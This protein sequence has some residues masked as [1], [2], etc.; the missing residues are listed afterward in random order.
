MSTVPQID[1][2]YLWVDGNDPVH[3]E[4]R[5]KQ[6]KMWKSRDRTA[7]AN[8]R[9]HDNGELHQSIL[10]ARKYAPWIRKIFIVVSLAQRPKFSQEFCEEKPPITFIDDCHLLPFTALPTFNSQ[11]LEANLHKIPDLSEQFL[12]ANDD[13]SFGAPVEPFDFFD[14]LTGF[15]RMIP[16]ELLP[17]P[18]R[19]VSIDVL[20]GWYS[21]RCNNAVLLN[22]LFGACVPPRREAK[23]QIRPLLK[24]TFVTM[25]SIGMIRKELA[26]T[27]N[28]RFRHHRNVEPVGL[29]MQ[30]A[31]VWRKAGPDNLMLRCCYIS[32]YDDTDWKKQSRVLHKK[33]PHLI[34]I[35]DEQHRHTD[36]AKTE[37]QECLQRYHAATATTADDT[38]CATK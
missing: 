13:E 36:H 27:T 25:W 5:T 31:K 15:P 19:Q 18:S 30:C 12:Y 3:M 37:M 17:V 34:C 29:A 35:N 4:E 2:V 20:P 11:A 33:R 7:V 16:G 21:A 23:H 32:W 10:S 38:F 24:S 28:S 26:Q 8:Y 9:W 1:I 14:E 22:K 6:L